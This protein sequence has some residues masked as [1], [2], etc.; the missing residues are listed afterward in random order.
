[1]YSLMDIKFLKQ[2]QNKL[3]AEKP[4]GIGGGEHSETKYQQRAGEVQRRLQLEV[5]SREGK[6]RVLLTGQIG[7]GKSSELWHFFRQHIQG[8]QGTAFCIFCDLE[9]ETHPEKCGATAVFLAILRDCWGATKQFRNKHH[10]D[11]DRVELSSIRDKILESL[12]DWLKG[13]RSN[14][15]EQVIFRFGGM[16]FPIGLAA[17]N[18]AQ[19]VALI[20]L[21]AAQH[22]AVSYTA[23]ERL[24]L[25]PDRLIALLNKLL[26][27]F[28][29]SHGGPAPLL[30]IDHVDKIRDES[31]A[32][33]VLV[34]IAPQWERINASIVMT[35]PYEYTLGEMRNSV[36]V[37]WGKP[38]MVYPLEIPELDDGNLPEI[39]T[40]IVESCGLSNLMDLESIRL[41]A[42]Y[43]GGIPRV[44]IQ[45]I[46]QA[47]YEAHLSE[48]G[49]IEPADVH[50]VIY[51]AETAY[52]DYGTKEL[53]L[54]GDISDNN[55]GLGKAATL[56]RSPIGLLIMPPEK[57]EQRIQVH[58]LAEPLLERYRIKTGRRAS[59]I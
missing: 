31:S 25:V 15:G 9:K 54:L 24:G 8:E 16:D 43:S 47:A 42:H 7:V 57:G 14:N 18:E 11:G 6:A 44:F 29:T 3:N 13:E 22:E 1:M 46:L 19:A 49:R 20:L 51:S 59:T 12:I 10:P 26:A 5:Y 36:E 32:R 28:Q 2:L 39:Y 40:K 41:L 48:H 53:A 38:L 30:I 55:F 23:E 37:C 56:L 34:E 35:A 21:K 33:E 4:A 50:S 58:P 45:L 17:D 52:Q 27:W